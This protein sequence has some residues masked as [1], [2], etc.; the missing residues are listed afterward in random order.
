LRSKRGSTVSILLVFNPLSTHKS[1]TGRNG[2]RIVKRALLLGVLLCP[3]FAIGCSRAAS[4]QIKPPKGHEGRGVA[5]A[6]SPEESIVKLETSE[7]RVIYLHQLKNDATFEPQK[8]AE[9]L[10]KY[11]GDSDQE[12]ATAAKELLDGPK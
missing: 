2:S 11:A 6:L 1:V 7:D 9:M 4:E 3:A 8:H 12:V 5:V 10:Q